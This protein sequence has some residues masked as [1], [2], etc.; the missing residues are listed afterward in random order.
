VG[1]AREPF[2]LQKQIDVLIEKDYIKR[3]AE[4]NDTY[5]YIA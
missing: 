2:I 3:L 4:E 1:E 5:E